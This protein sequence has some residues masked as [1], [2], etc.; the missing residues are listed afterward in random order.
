MLGP[1]MRNP[2]AKARHLGSAHTGTGHFLTQRTTAAANLF[3]VTAFVV[4]LASL[5]GAS[6]EEALATLRN[7]FIAIVML[8]AILNVTL[9]MRVGMQVIIEDYMHGESLKFV[10]LIANVFYTAAIALASVFAV[11]KVNFGS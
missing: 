2:L 6:Y 7:P 10:A 11:L 3:L 4:I 9:H 1:G 5:A 8:L